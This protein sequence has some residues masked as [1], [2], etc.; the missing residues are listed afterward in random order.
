M[1]PFKKNDWN[2]ILRNA[3]M[4]FLNSC[5]YFFISST[6]DSFISNN[7]YDYTWYNN[8]SHLDLF[9]NEWVQCISLLKYFITIPSQITSYFTHEPSCG[10]T[11]V[12]MAKGRCTILT[13]KFFKYSSISIYTHQYFN[14]N[15]GSTVTDKISKTIKNMICNAVQKLNQH[16]LNVSCVDILSQKTQNIE[17]ML[18]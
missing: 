16:R 3:C 10:S 8:H 7:I 15:L 12:G 2:K 17:P 6:L 13:C 9:Q 18:F 4:P 5:V 1:V 11:R 14:D